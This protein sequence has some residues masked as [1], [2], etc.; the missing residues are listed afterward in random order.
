MNLKLKDIYNNNKQRRYCEI[1]GIKKEDVEIESNSFRVLKEK[2]YLTLII[3]VIFLSL[4]SFW[5]NFKS[6][7]FN[8]GSRPEVGSS[9]II[10]SPH[11]ANA[12]IR[13]TLI[14]F[15]LESI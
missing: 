8:I 1:T 13:A 15:P 14:L 4:T 10:Y 7:F 12:I 2:K 11:C 6:L 5:R 3:I 9:K